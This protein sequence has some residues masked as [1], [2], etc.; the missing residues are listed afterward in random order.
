[1]NQINKKNYNNPYD[2]LYFFKKL[3][4]D[5]IIDMLNK[6]ILID[7]D[8]F[9]LKK[10]IPLNDINEINEELE[11][12]DE[13]LKIIYKYHRSPI[14]IE[15]DLTPL[16]DAATKGAVLSGI[17][18]FEFIHLSSSVYQNRR[19]LEL[20]TKEAKCSVPYFEKDVNNFII[21][22]EVDKILRK[23]LNDEG[24][25]LDDATPELKKIRA[26]IHNLE[27]RIKSKVNEIM[28]A[29]KDFLADN[30]IVKR[31]DRYCLCIKA[32]YKNSFHGILRDTSQTALTCYIEPNLT[33]QM[34]NERDAYKNEEKEEVNRI[35]RNLSLIIG[36]HSEEYKIDFEILKELD[37]R[38]AKAIL[39]K[40]YDGAKPHINNNQIFNLVEARHPLLEVEKVI[41]NS[42]SF[43]QDHLGIV[44][45]GPNTGGKTVFLKTIGLLSLMI[46]FGLLIPAK[47]ESNLMIY[48]HI[49]ADIGDDQSISLN[50]STFSSHM[51]KMVA[52][53]DKVTP[54]SLAL[55]DE[56]GSGTDPNEGSSLAIGVLKYFINNKVSF[57]V[58]THYAELKA[59]AYGTKEAINASMQFDEKTSNPTYQLI[60]G[61]SGSSNAFY[62][63]RRLGLKKEIIDDSYKICNNQSSYEVRSLIKILET[64]K[65]HLLKQN[66]ELQNLINSN[67][68][69]QLELDKRLKN[70]ENE[71]KL[72]IKEAHNQAE[73]IYNDAITQANQIIDELLEMKKKE[74]NSTIKLHEI[75][76]KKHRVNEMENS[77]NDFDDNFNN[78]KTSMPHEFIVGDNVYLISYEQYGIITKIFKD[79]SFEITIGSLKIHA[80]KEDL[81]YEQK[82]DDGLK[83]SINVLYTPNKKVSLSLDLR[84]KRVQEAADLLDKYIDDLII[85]NIKSATIIHGFGTGAIREYVLNYLK[86]SKN[87]KEYRH[88]EDGEGGYGVTVITLK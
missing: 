19:L 86:Q 40:S 75:I 59:W 46:K 10:M 68:E 2:D 34:A 43:G 80:D 36:N 28:L 72:K 17:D 14:Y 65:V 88:G 70:I 47:E 26:R 27:E 42:V 63:A 30:V 31:D 87:I 21:D 5:K 85:S 23:S 58:T 67:K 61:Q 74:E 66:D 49:L 18:L 83:S 82:Y 12:V 20:L 8:Y 79:K 24:Y 76:D 9:D 4:L 60:I 50:L 77:S 53:V 57:I 71:K 45:T 38:F 25:V 54:N 69:K 44:I 22:Q 62:T 81:R 39:A 6:N 16:L 33:Y 37:K 52:I 51:K 73:R 78:N 3:E 11:K 7:I 55:F 29:S 15:R 13:A 56:I 48:D 35:L 84:G 41:P 1:M 32:E 64:E